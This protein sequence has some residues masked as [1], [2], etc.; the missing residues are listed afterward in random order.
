MRPARLR[1][2]RAPARSRWSTL[3]RRSRAERPAPLTPQ[4][5]TLSAMAAAPTASKVPAHRHDYQHDGRAARR[6]R[7]HRHRSERRGLRR[8]WT[9]SS[10]HGDT[11]EPVLVRNES[12]RR[13]PLEP[14]ECPD[15]IRLSSDSCRHAR[16]Q[17]DE[18]RPGRDRQPLDGR[19]LHN[20]RVLR[21]WHPWRCR[22]ERPHLLVE[23]HGAGS[24]GRRSPVAACDDH[25]R[26]IA[27]GHD[28]DSADARG[29]DVDNR[30]PRHPGSGGTSPLLGQIVQTTGIVT[31]IRVLGG[32]GLFIQTDDADIDGDPATSEGVFVFTSSVAPRRRPSALVSRCRAR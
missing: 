30:D 2:R 19:R 32:N 15:G 17:S 25:G 21:R 14:I 3:R 12:N 8:R 27:H 10:E 5:S 31:G 20:H 16:R 9:Q 18:H 11:C 22:P 26:A 13:R 24:D 1:W 28:V 6:W 29:V 7:V 23:L 4:L